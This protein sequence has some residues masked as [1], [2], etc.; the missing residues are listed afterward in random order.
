MMV[1]IFEKST[2]SGKRQICLTP[3]NITLLDKTIPE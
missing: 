1:K 2:I 3:E